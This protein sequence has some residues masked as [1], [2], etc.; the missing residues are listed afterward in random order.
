MP[1]NPKLN[2]VTGSSAR[3]YEYLDDYS[4]TKNNHIKK[5]VK[6]TVI[7]EKLKIK[8][9]FLI[10]CLFVMLMIITYRFNVISESN[11]TLQTLKADLERVQSNLASTE[12]SIEQSTDLSKIE[13]YAKQKLGMQKPDKNQV[14]YIDTSKDTNVVKETNISFVDK[15][16]ESIKRHINNI[17]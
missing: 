17:K 2:Y 8:T 11:L 9:V 7:N 6:K 12:M 13:A 15:I 3:K 5:V 1:A 4:K 10:S 16:I 14:V